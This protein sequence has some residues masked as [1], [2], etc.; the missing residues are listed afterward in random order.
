MMKPLD[1]LINHKG[2]NLNQ[3]TKVLRKEFKWIPYYFDISTYGGW[4]SPTGKYYNNKAKNYSNFTLKNS[5]LRLTP[6]ER[7]NYYL[8]DLAYMKGWIEF[9]YWQSYGGNVVNFSKHVKRRLTIVL[10]PGAALSSE[11]EYLVTNQI[12]RFYEKLFDK[13]EFELIEIRIL[14]EDNEDLPTIAT[15]LTAKRFFSS[16]AIEM[17]LRRIRR[18]AIAS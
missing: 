13:I 3:A 10:Y 12:I 6:E 7:E 5:E 4:L 1:T 18:R 9:R 16:R 15:E 14:N 11:N 8:L 17:Y 2:Y